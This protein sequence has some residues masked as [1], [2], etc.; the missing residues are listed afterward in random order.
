MA[1]ILDIIFSPHTGISEIILKEL[2]H[3]FN[4]SL[5]KSTIINLTCVMIRY[6]LW[7]TFESNL[8][9]IDED[10]IID[11]GVSLDMGLE[12]GDVGIEDTLYQYFS[13]EYDYINKL[14]AFLK[15]RIRTIKSETP[16]HE[17]F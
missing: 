8:A 6:L 12:S 15:R 14:S 1:L 3:F 10:T 5:K 4:S 2:K 13:E 9:S 11:I 7:N 16:C 17:P